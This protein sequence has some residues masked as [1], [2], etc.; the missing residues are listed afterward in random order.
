MIARAEIDRLIPTIYEA[1][2]EPEAWLDVLETIRRG[3]DISTALLGILPADQMWQGIMWGANLDPA[4]IDDCLRYGVIDRSVFA[5]ALTYMPLGSLA[6]L[7]AAGERAVY[8]DPGA[9]ALLRAQS[10]TEGLF[11][12]VTRD[13]EQ[14]TGLACLNENSRGALDAS[15]VRWIESLVPHIS[16]SLAISWHIEQLQREVT[17][18]RAALGQ[19]VV[20]VMSVTAG[21]ILRYTNA[22]AERILSL[23]DGLA[24]HGK[25]LRLVDH[26]VKAQLHATVARFA[27]RSVGA[28]PPCLFVPRP[29]GAPSYTLVV[30]PAGASASAGNP[31]AAATLFVTDPVGPKALPGPVLLA[32]GLGLTATEAEVARLAAMGRGMGFVAENLGI[33]LN[34]ARTHLKA[35]YSK[36]GVHHQAALAR[37]IA[38]R[39]P[40]IA[41]LNGEKSEA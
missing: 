13:S 27:T 24:Q 3:A 15:A 4:S 22:E 11:G 8:N 14:I 20:G 25:R 30:A 26:D 16:R 10:L 2:A 9:Q 18:L 34:T 35:I 1:S 38:D 31:S 6:D 21:L 32:E 7:G 39:F 19:L 23:A 37:T 28:G 41:G 40:P 36:T 29:S 5:Q 33:S 12:P 17:S